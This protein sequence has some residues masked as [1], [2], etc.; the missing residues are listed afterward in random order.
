MIFQVKNYTIL[1]EKPSVKRSFMPSR[2]DIGLRL[3]HT[4]HRQKSLQGELPNSFSPAPLKKWER[5][6]RTVTD[7]LKICCGCRSTE[8]GQNLTLFSQ[9]T[10]KEKNTKS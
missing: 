1:R 4:F 10:F 2:Y 9:R 5:I 6:L 7:Y 8:T 3:F